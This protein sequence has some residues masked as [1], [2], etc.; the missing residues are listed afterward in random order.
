MKKIITFIA[1]LLI[2]AVSVAA[3]NATFTAD[4]DDHPESGARLPL[5]VGLA[6]RLQRHRHPELDGRCGRPAD[7]DQPDADARAAARASAS[8]ERAFGRHAEH[9]EFLLRHHPVLWVMT[10]VRFESTG[11]AAQMVA[12]AAAIKSTL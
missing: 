4:T 5:P 3:P 11:T 10:G 12:Q 9:V 7:A 1:G 2:A 6:R 8:F